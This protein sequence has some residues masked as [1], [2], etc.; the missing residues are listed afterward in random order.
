MRDDPMEIAFRYTRE[1]WVRF[2]TR[3]YRT[4]LYGLKPLNDVGLC[5]F[6]ALLLLAVLGGLG[7]VG[8]VGYA[9]WNGLAWYWVVGPSLV[10]LYFTGMAM[11]ILRPRR[12]PVR[13]F[14]IELAFRFKI[15]KDLIG[16]YAVRAEQSLRRQEEKGEANFG[17]RYLLSIDPDGYTLVTEYPASSAN[18][19]RLE[20]RAEWAAVHTVEVEDHFL[21]LTNADGSTVLVPRW[22]FADEGA[23]QRFADVANE[24]RANSA[25]RGATKSAGIQLIPQGIRV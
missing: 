5:I 16:K 3:T 14:F 7:L 18:T 23:C 22:N 4:W 11:E 24:Y 6:T 17:H 20:N 12:R 8:F 15:E 10:A 19:A 25:P 2:Q 21:A 1:D 9:A 13:P